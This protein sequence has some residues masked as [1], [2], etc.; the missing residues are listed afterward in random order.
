MRFAFG[1]AP[2]LLISAYREIQTWDYGV[3]EEDL[4]GFT[5]AFGDL[6]RVSA[7]LFDAYNNI[8]KVGPLGST[9]PKDGTKVAAISSTIELIKKFDRV[10]I[11]WV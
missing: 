5:T 11:C 1:V 4:I 8:R 6:Y 3:M 2:D 9:P 7:L 10:S